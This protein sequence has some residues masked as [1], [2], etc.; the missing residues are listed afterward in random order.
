MSTSD[1][2]IEIQHNMAQELRSKLAPLLISPA[3]GWAVCTER[4]SFRPP[5]ARGHRERK[6][7]RQLD[8]VVPDGSPAAASAISAIGAHLSVRAV[9]RFRWA[10]LPLHG[11]RSIPALRFEGL[12]R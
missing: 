3:A 8:G 4:R 12:H 10:V 11:A 1:K 7:R 9:E 5:L 6:L 2:T